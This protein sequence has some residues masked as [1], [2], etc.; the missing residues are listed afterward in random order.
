MCT[1]P[2]K[3]GQALKWYAKADCAKRHTCEN[4]TFRD[5]LKKN[6]KMITFTSESIML[7]KMY[8]L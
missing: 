6:G 1:A 5:Q 2:A 8:S 4:I 7:L 3:E